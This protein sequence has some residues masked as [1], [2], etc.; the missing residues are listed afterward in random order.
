[1]KDWTENHEAPNELTHAIIGAAIEVHKTLG[2]GLMESAY[3]KCLEREFE[4]RGIEYISETPIPVHYKGVNIDASYRIDFL[5]ADEV[6]VE[7]KAVEKILPIHEA[8]L[9]TY[10]KITRKR[11]GLL[12][13]FNSPN[14]SQG[15]RRILNG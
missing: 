13:N 4:L 10:L 5:V 9:L 12:M 1:V 6:I 11:L 15:T 2:P 3:R 7:L 14:L 8:Q